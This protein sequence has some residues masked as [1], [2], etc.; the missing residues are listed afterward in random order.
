MQRNKFKKIGIVSTSATVRNKLFGN[1]FQ[2]NNIIYET[3]DELQQEKIGKFIHNLVM[4]RH[5]NK[6]REELISIIN[7]FQKKQVDCVAL[8][9]TDLQ[10]LIPKHPSLKIF[11]TMKILVDAT[12]DFM[13]KD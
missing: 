10:L 3:P 12:V 5:N 7:D 4:G 8:A 11:D 1:A 2:E 13:I 9:C 6:D